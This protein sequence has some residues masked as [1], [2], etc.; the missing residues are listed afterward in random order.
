MGSLLG[1]FVHCL[2]RHSRSYHA[3]THSYN[4]Q[5]WAA[6]FI[7]TVKSYQQ[8][9]RVLRHLQ[10]IGTQY[11]LQNVALRSSCV[12]NDGTQSETREISES[13]KPDG[14]QV[15]RKQTFGN[16]YEYRHLQ[17]RT[18]L[19]YQHTTPRA[20]R[21]DDHDAGVFWKHGARGVHALN[22]ARCE[23]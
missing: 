15:P 17:P 1:R 22:R 21:D 20:P 18:A 2:P 12:P 23:E 13:H 19:A 16:R 14:A 3:P 6:T 11:I 8:L 10:I 9:Y 5:H 4:P 7:I